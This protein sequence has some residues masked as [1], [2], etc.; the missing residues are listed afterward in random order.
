MSEKEDDNKKDF[1]N[2]IDPDKISKNPHSLEY[3]HHLG[4]AVVKPEDM[5]KVKGRAVTAMEFQ[6]DQQLNQLYEQMQ[7]LAEQAKKINERKAISER[8]YSASFRFDPIINHVY[9]L[10]ED[11]SQVQILSIIGPNEWGRSRKNSYHYIATVRLL[12]D[13]T[14]EIMHSSS[15]DQ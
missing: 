8:I 2:P 7:L 1:Q 4:S 11:E 13:H 14:W 9:Y 6:T 15:E 10:Y 5:G 12:A 3:G